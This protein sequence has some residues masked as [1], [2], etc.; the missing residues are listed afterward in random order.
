MSY[1][2]SSGISILNFTDEVITAAGGAINTFRYLV[3]Y[4]D[5]AASDELLGWLDYGSVVDLADTESLTIDLGV[6]G[7]MQITS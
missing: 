1:A 3:V 2:E 7:L 4:N 6:A 5:T